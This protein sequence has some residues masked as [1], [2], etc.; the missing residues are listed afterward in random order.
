MDMHIPYSL[1]IKVGDY[2][3]GFTNQVIAE[4]GEG[5]TREK[6]ETALVPVRFESGLYA[7][8]Y[9]FGPACVTF[10][11]EKL[12]AMP[13]IFES[14]NKTQWYASLHRPNSSETLVVFAEDPCNNN[15]EG[16]PWQLFISPTYH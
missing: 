12:R 6:T 3:G 14:D 7:I 1:P 2:L 13:V 15:T 8:I 11:Q 5:V 10:F 9:C 16:D 4:I